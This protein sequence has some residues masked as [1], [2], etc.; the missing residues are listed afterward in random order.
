M[1][2]FDPLTLLTGGLIGFISALLA[3][4]VRTW[5]FRPR[6]RL[7]FVEDADHFLTE[8]KERIGGATADH[9][10]IY[11]RVHVV[12]RSWALAKS[13]RAYLA[14]MERLGGSGKWENTTYCESLPLSW[15]GY[16]ES[17]F[18]PLDLSQ[19][20]T[21]VVDV[22]STREVS[23]SFKLETLCILKRYEELMR[24]HE[25]YRLTVL[26]SGDGV[27]PASMKLIF[28]WTGVWDGFEV[29]QDKD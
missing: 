18:A 15:A 6:L 23:P 29:S 5:L 14:N 9:K 27:R 11:V 8:T 12:N 21:H 20:V 4:P 25:T 26:V 16:V 10:A 19:N 2:K 24:T 7:T 1:N 3:E 28:K 13:C 22:L 17:R